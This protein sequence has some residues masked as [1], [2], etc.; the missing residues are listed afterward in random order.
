M[1]TQTYPGSRAEGKGPDGAEPE[2]LRCSDHSS[3]IG[4]TPR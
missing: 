4:E 1:A 2:A 3:P